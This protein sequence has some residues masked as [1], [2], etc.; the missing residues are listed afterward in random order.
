LTSTMAKAE[1]TRRLETCRRLRK[2]EAQRRSGW[3]V[4]GFV[5]PRRRAW[6]WGWGRGED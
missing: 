1:R 6:G 5:K 2:Y 3:P 4:P